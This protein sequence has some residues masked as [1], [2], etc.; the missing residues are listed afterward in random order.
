MK[1]DKTRIYLFEYSV[2]FLFEL[3]IIIY[4]KNS[5]LQSKE[6]NKIIIEKHFSI[7]INSNNS[8]YNKFINLNERD[9]KGNNYVTKK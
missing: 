7:L 1:N 9:N 6:L 5:Q 3:L 4:N 2:Y 8:N